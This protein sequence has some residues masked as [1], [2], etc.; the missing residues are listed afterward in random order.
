M[1]ATFQLLTIDPAGMTVVVDIK[2]PAGTSITCYTADGGAT[3]HTLPKTISSATD[4]HI[5]NKGTYTVSVRLGGA[6]IGGDTVE[7][8][9]TPRIYRVNPVNTADLVAAFSLRAPGINAQTGT[10]YALVAA[11][12]GKIVTLSNA[13]PV[14]LTLPVDADY[15]IGA[16]TKLV[17]L[18]VGLV[19]IAAGEGA[20]IRNPGATGDFAAQ[21]TVVDA[22]KIAA[23]TWVVHGSFAAGS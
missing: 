9:G 20:T 18:G 17:Q 16:S 5:V 14:T 22:I 19:S 23:A 1:P 11:D 12:A 15:P 3:T 2:D 6:E 13:N 10:T 7:L 8:A 4:F 21:Y